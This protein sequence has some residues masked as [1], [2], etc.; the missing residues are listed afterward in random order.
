M[1]LYLFLLLV[2]WLPKPLYGQLKEAINELGKENITIDSTLDL[3]FLLLEFFLDEIS[4]FYK[5]QFL[6]ESGLLQ[7]V[8]VN[9]IELRQEENIETVLMRLLKNT[10]LVSVKISKATFVLV[11][12][13]QKGILYG[14]VK[15]KNLRHL[16]GATIRVLKE[17]KGTVTNIDG[18]YSLK[19]EEGI[20]ELEISYV[21]FKTIYRKLELLAGD[22]LQVDFNLLDFPTL[23]EV[24]IVGA[25]FS[26]MS[27]LE[28]T[29]PADVLNR[30]ALDRNSFLNL[31]ESLHFQIPSFHATSQTISDGTDHVIPATLR[32]LGSDQLL[33][34]INGKRRH[35]SSLVNINGTV[36]RG[37]VATDLNAI[38]S[39]AIDKIEVL[40]DGA[41]AQYGSDAIAGVINIVLKNNVGFTNVNALIGLTQSGDGTNYQ[42][43]GNYGLKLGKKGGFA[44]FTMDFRRSEAVNRAGNYT[45][46]IFGDDRDFNADSLQLFFEQTG[47]D[48][49]RVMSVGNAAST[50]AGL[51]FNA[52]VPLDEKIELYLFGTI[53]YRFG[54]SAGFYRF[55]YQTTRQSG[56]FHFGFSPKL[57]VNIFDRSFTIGIKSKDLPW[58]VDFSNT[59]GSN[60]FDFTVVNSNNASM[61]LSSPTSAKAGGFSYI[62]NVSNLD[63][64]KRLDFK[65]PTLLGFGSEFR[66]ENYRQKAGE[67]SSWRQYGGTT[68][69][70]LPKESGIQMFPGF[71]PENVSNQYRYNIGIYSNVESELSKT[72]MLNLGA[73]Y[74]FY[75]DFG[76]NLILKLGARYN[77]KNLLSFRGTFNTGFRAPSMPQIHF[78]SRASQFVSVGN[79]Q[80]GIDVAHFNNGNNVTRQFGIAPLKAETS[81]SY[82]FGMAL[83]LPLNLAMTLD[84]YQIDIQDRIVITGR[85]T[86]DDDPRLATILEPTGASKAQFFTNAI[87]TKTRG[88]DLRINY[89]INFRQS[90]LN[91]S[92]ASAIHRTQLKRDAKGKTLIKT[93]EILKAY[94]DVLFNREE[95]ARVELA[96]PRSKFILSSQY[97]TKN[98]DLNLS[99]TR[100][101]S[102]EYIHPEDGDSNNWV[103]NE[104]TGKIETRDQLFSAKWITNIAWTYR[105]SNRINFSLAA[106]NVFNIFPDK[107][108]HSANISKGVFLYSRRVQQFGVKGAYWYTK[109]SFKF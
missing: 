50:N 90:A 51:V 14:K 89:S 29:E 74:E 39:S 105:F 15:G 3:N 61:G 21:G 35:H 57:N 109:V 77:I 56:L 28:R 60:S 43:N 85:F 103:L 52:E 72:L 4:D 86:S 107:H 5:V 10:N 32:G 27:L 20:H 93:S 25:R 71:R 23:N 6:Y 58:Q 94:E 68:I 18:Q 80:K 33:V 104:L 49:Q 91:L 108:Q 22:S 41:A 79:E 46:T 47:F 87:D 69:S 67:T 36:G 1:F 38:P 106:N 34:L 100:F 64:S 30:N 63:V 65:F 55:P 31:S 95:I 19:L 45:G 13:E 54:E 76:S 24:T 66:L 96:Q 9:Y 92:L 7:K 70:G 26:S 102:V 98:W 88:L 75:S 42:I 83:S 17:E 40:K 37:S 73:R 12:K 62:Q 81:E 48:A 8:K 99:F 16:A 97:K 59:F 101:G 44:N 84:V 11:K 82:S 78:S 53:N 2:L